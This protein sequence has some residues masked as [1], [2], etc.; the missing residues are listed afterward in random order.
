MTGVLRTMSITPPSLHPRNPLAGLTLAGG[1]VAIDFVNTVDHRSASEPNDRLVSP[2]DLLWWGNRVGV[3]TSGTVEDLLGSVHRNP[4]MADAVLHRSLSLREACFRLFSDVIDDASGSTD[5]LARLNRELKEG[6]RH[7]RLSL[8]GSRFEWGWE[9]ISEPAQ[10]LGRI[11]HS[12]AELLAS[13]DLDRLGRCA[14]P[15]CDWLFLDVSRNRSR[16]WCDMAECGNRAKMRRFY[17]RKRG[18]R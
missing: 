9:E 5:D 16:R 12:G 7:R 1:A 2:E 8:E 13:A 14:A 17:R 11:A 3:L 18:E 10:L 4:S 15:D 6:S